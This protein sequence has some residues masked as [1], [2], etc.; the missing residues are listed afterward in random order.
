MKT[1][2]LAAI[3]GVS[4]ATDCSY[5]YD[6]GCS[7]G[8]ATTNPPE[9]AD[10]SFQTY[11]PGSSSYEEQYQGLGRIMCYNQILYDNAVQMSATVH[12]HCRTHESITSV[13][14]NWNG[15]GFKK[16]DWYQADSTMKDAVT[17]EVKASD[18]TNDY[19]ISLE[20]V[21]FLWQAEP[22]V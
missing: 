21:N 6:L 8:D 4:T 22:I 12:A 2:A 7:S 9:W 13:Q 3:A 20:P 10:R 14:Y 1:F 5:F 17:L 18:G 11:L 16:Y 15:E 19:I